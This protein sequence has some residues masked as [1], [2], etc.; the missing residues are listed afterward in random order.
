MM[1]EELWERAKVNTEILRQKIGMLLVSENTILDYIFLAE[2]KINI[3]DTIIRKGKIIV[4]KPLIIL[5]DRFPIFEGFEWD[6]KSEMLVPFLLIRGVSF[7]SLKY[8]NITSSIEV[9]E[10]PLNKAIEDFNDRLSQK[11][12][13]STGLIKGEEDIWQFS[14]LIYVAALI[15][16]AAPRDIKRVI[17]ILKNF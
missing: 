11:E 16:R 3:G 17:D 12:D 10:G 8:K 7:P 15:A 1:L 14:L 4:Y 9:Y 6:D 2:S 5:P 13:V